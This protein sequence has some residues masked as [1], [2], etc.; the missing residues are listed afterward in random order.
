ME[1][2]TMNHKTKSTKTTTQASCLK[3][4]DKTAAAS[5]ALQTYADEITLSDTADR[6]SLEET[7]TDLL[8]DLRHLAGKT[9]VDFSEALRLSLRHY[10]AECS[11]TLFAPRRTSSVTKN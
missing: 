2:T 8:T 9:G 7:L 1:T 4:Q 6:Q 5:I 11:T 3:D 10:E